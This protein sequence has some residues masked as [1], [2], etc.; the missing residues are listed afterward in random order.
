[1]SNLLPESIRDPH[2][3]AVESVLIDRETLFELEKLVPLLIDTTPAS[4]LTH[5]AEH[6]SIL[7]IEG[8]EFVSTD[9]DKRALL[10]KAIEL[11]RKKGT[12]YSI[13]NAVESVGYE[14]VQVQEGLDNFTRVIDNIDSPY[15]LLFNGRANYDG[16]FDYGGGTNG[17]NRVI[18]NAPHIKW[19]LFRVVITIQD[20]E[21]L[22]EPTKE[23]IKL[24]IDE[25]KNVRSWLT[26]IGIAYSFNETLPFTETRTFAVTR[27]S[28]DYFGNADLF[29]G[30]NSFD[31]AIYYRNEGL[32]DAID[33]EFD[34]AVHYDGEYNYDSGGWYSGQT[35]V[36]MPDYPV[37]VT[38][39]RTDTITMT[40]NFSMIPA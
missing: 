12:P 3:S 37:N 21:T 19:A 31:G 14:K 26:D 5:L 17:I 1:M 35:Y 25:Y 27:N 23:R 33:A 2:Y 29:D 13:K 16:T 40:E 10:K 6:L 20:D 32:R 24:M 22:D 30:T 8:W 18:V 34:A 11:H 4:A 38:T 36:G 9:A 28:I 15:P 39:T 7:G